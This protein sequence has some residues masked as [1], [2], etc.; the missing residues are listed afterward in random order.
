M[1]QGIMY[2]SNRSTTGDKYLRARSYLTANADALINL[3]R[4]LATRLA[5]IRGDNY[6]QIQHDYNS[7]SELYPFWQRYPPE[8]RGRK[9]IGDQY[10]WIEVG[11]HAVGTWLAINLGRY[12]SVDNLTLPTGPDQRFVVTH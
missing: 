9:P 2:P 7:S 12:F 5:Q 3:E 11:E 10:P 4:V 1:S 6:N 8:E